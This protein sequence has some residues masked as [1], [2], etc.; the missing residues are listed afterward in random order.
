L[1]G[2]GVD[3]PKRHE[4]YDADATAAGVEA[5]LEVLAKLA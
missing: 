2:G 1:L 5:A 3:T 4:P